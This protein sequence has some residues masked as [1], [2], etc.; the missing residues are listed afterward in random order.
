MESGREQAAS[1]N[2]GGVDTRSRGGPEGRIYSV[3]FAR[4]WDTIVAEIQNRPRWRLVHSDE[5]LGLLTV[6]CR[7]R[8]PRRLDDLAIW[9]SLDENGFT[10]VDLRSG[11]RA[12]EKHPDGTVKPSHGKRITSILAA[13]DDRLG[14][15]TRLTYTR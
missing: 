14:H 3:P 9:V 11:P 15:E 10:R 8:L 4:V 13:L 6:T 12:T 1:A 2:G 5:G 7:S